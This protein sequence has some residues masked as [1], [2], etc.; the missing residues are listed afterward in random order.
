MTRRYDFLGCPIDDY[1]FDEVVSEIIRR[2]KE[3]KRTNLVHFL[4]VSKIVKARKNKQLQQTLW[5]GDFVLADG[6]PLLPFGRL[7]GISLPTRVNGTDLMEK[8]LEISAEEGFR[9][10]LLGAKQ[11]VIEK[12][13]IKIRRKHPKINICGYRNGYFQE[14]EVGAITEAI[15]K[16]K[17]DIA[18]IGMGTP[19]KEFFAHQNRAKLTVPI[20]EGVGGSFDVLGGFVTR[21]PVWMQQAGLEWFYRV[22]QEPK[23]MFWR[24]FYTNTIFFIIFLKYLITRPF[25]IKD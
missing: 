5:A 10:Y 20:V 12:C 7:L 25:R 3:K 1:S 21:A 8:L 24:Y 11:E 15:N 13:V 14:D 2:I 16:S 23:R 19:Q 17:A 22:L 9:V 4:N 18:F 6:K